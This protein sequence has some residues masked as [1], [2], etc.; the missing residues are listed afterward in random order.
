MIT[1][2]AVGV[3]NSKPSVSKYVK[4]YEME[5]VSYGI[6]ILDNVWSDKLFVLQVRNKSII[7]SG[8]TAL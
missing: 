3:G 6:Y 8:E 2:K 7:Y 5:K 1:S 4:D